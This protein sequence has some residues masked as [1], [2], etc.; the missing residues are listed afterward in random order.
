MIWEYLPIAKC[1]S[2]KWE[3]FIGEIVRVKYY[4]SCDGESQKQQ[5]VGTL[6]IE[7]YHGL[8]KD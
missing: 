7:G 1:T 4:G 8:N 6:D 2:A 3:A 5:I